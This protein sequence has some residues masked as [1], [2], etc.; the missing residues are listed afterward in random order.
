M[1]K[2]VFFCLA[3]VVFQSSGNLINAQG[4]VEASSDDGPQ[5]VGY[6]QPEFDYYFYG[7]DVNFDNPIRPSTFYFQRA[8]V[9]V[10]GSIP[11][12][13]SYYIM[14][15]FSPIWTGYPYL[16][17]AYVTYS[18]FGKYAKFSIGQFKQPFSLELNT[19]CFALHTVNRSL[20]TNQLAGP[21]RE[22]GFMILGSVGK[23]RD[24]LSYRLGILNGT[25][26]NHLDNNAN[27]ALSGRVTVSPWE[28]LTIG[29]SA[30]YELV[31]LEGIEGQPKKQRYAGELTFEGWNFRL[32]GEYMFGTD[33]DKEGGGSSGGGGCGGKA[34][35]AGLVD[36]NKSGFWV[37]AM[38]MT[39]INLQPVVKYEAYDSGDT[40]YEFNYGPMGSED[41][42]IPQDYPQSTLTLGLNY[43]LNDWTRV[44][45]NYLLNYE[46]GENADG[47]PNE[48][49]NNALL[50]QVQAKF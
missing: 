7:N 1:K 30:R 35:N 11:Y 5:L 43:F 38:Y 34:V 16:L 31:G 22:L 41:E 15:E 13:V 44:Q 10:L 12:D 24:I 45:V 40:Q 50:I 3:L 9:G 28:F 14:A 27:K 46:G 37:M 36:F 21:F 48:F 2:I 25:G 33:T 23:N 17:D 47:Q 39:S 26:I 32:Q 18:P 8:R 42:V 29:G 6:I 19:P 4:C 20:V 49:Q